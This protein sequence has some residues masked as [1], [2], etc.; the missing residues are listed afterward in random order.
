MFLGVDHGTTA[1]R[2]AMTDGQCWELSRRTA[3]LLSPGEIISE[4]RKNLDIPHVDMVAMTYSMGDG[5]TSIMRLED[6]PNRGLIQLDG[7]GLHQGGGTRVFEAIAGSGWPAILL[8][9]IHRQSDIDPRM[10]V[11]SHGMS[12]EKV[13]LAYGIYKKGVPS[14]IVC[15]ASSNTVTFCVL[16]G[17]IVGAID[18]PIFAPGLMQGPLDV[19]AIRAVDAGRMTA[20][21]AFTCAGILHKMGHA[22]LEECSSEERT[23]AVESLALFAAMEI[24]AMLVLSRDL[25][26]RNPTIFLAGSPAPLLAMRVSELLE[27]EVEIKGKCA[28]A[29]G[30]A[31]IA[32]DVFEGSKN[33]LGLEVDVRARTREAGSGIR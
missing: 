17:R 15:D 9:G 4:V 10:R 2:F 29:Q 18:A 27:K 32:K 13:G 25:S 31:A 1:I 24:N 12:P 8:P 19:E 22:T 3:S 5:I 20:N 6:A 28:A 26:E 7:A 14:F 21:Q 33:I 16:Q 30:C 23:L 11:F